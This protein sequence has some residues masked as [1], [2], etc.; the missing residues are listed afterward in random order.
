MSHISPYFPIFHQISPWFLLTFWGPPH[1]PNLKPPGTPPFHLSPGL[2]D[3]VVGSSSFGSHHH[4]LLLLGLRLI[5]FGAPFQGLLG[6]GDPLLMSRWERSLEKWVCL[7]MVS[8]PKPNGFA[9]HYP[10]FKWLF[11]WEYTLFSDKPKSHW[12][13]SRKNLKT[14]W[15][16]T[17]QKWVSLKIVEA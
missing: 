5:F 13:I 2:A 9:D 12:K 3:Q 1:P 10:V 15:R 11:H 6:W 14:T 8:T 16:S 4:H 7:K 17:E